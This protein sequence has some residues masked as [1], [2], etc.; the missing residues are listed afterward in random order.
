MSQLVC[1]DC[2]QVLADDIDDDVSQ[3]ALNDL[4][5]EDQ[6]DHDHEDEGDEDAESEDGSGLDDRTDVE[7]QEDDLEDEFDEKLDEV[8]DDEKI[9]DT[10]DDVEEYANAADAEDVDLLVEVGSERTVPSD[11]W[12]YCRNEA[13]RITP[14][15]KDKLRQRRKDKRRTEQRAGSFDSNRMMAASRGSARVFEREEP[16]DERRYET[17]IVLDRSS[18][19]RGADMKSAELSTAT[20]MI[21]LEEAGVKTELVDFYSSDARLIKTRSQD[22][23]DE[24]GSIL[25]GSREVS[26]GTPIGKVMRLVAERVDGVRDQPFV[27]V[28]TDGKPGNRDEYTSALG[29]LNQ[30]DV[31]VIGVTVGRGNKISESTMNDLFN[32]WVQVENNDELTNRL[33]ELARGVMF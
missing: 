25:R 30:E 13:R 28:V 18:S 32:S 31:P 20:L 26:G 22:A 5:I 29:D 15:L 24:G 16:G 8:T 1:E 19:M 10:T 33:E 14:I 4:D 11:R 12:D 27:I 6:R 2:G 23:K 9:D 3:E 17:Y 7:E 21:A